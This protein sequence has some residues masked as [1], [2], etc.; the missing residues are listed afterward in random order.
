ML[1]GFGSHCPSGG[2][3]S[4]IVVLPDRVAWS[5]MNGTV[6]CLALSDGR[7][8]WRYDAGGPV[9][10]SGDADDN[11]IVIC[12]NAVFDERT[13]T[14][15]LNTSVETN[16]PD[17][18]GVVHALDH[19]GTLRW[20]HENPEGARFPSL[21]GD[22]VYYHTP[23]GLAAY[24]A[25]GTR[26]WM[27]TEGNLAVAPPALD[28]AAGIGVSAEDF[29]GHH[30]H[31]GLRVTDLATG[32]PLWAVDGSKQNFNP[33]PPVV[34]FGS[35]WMIGF[36][37]REHDRTAVRLNRFDLRSGRL[38]ATVP[39]GTEIESFATCLAAD[40]TGIL[41]SYQGGRG[42]NDGV[43]HIRADNG[44]PRLIQ[45]IPADAAAVTGGRALLATTTQLCAVDVASGEQLWS[46]E[47][48]QNAAVTTWDR[49]VTVVPTAHGV[50]WQ[51]GPT[52][53]M[54]RSDR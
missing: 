32:Q 1:P 24:S 53:T 46:L 23:Y 12:S 11:L 17:A 54:L 31:G 45:P 35:V 10:T 19:D 47:N 34:A 5:S 42:M 2:R 33:D 44:K 4:G 37:F 38:L 43:K 20:Q 48:P 26:H 3:E 7:E 41:V 49:V 6:R 50:L 51:A 40:E 29:E 8:L 25:D 15:V 21:S 36:V 13:H 9:V 14:W 39:L 22:T 52:V 18:G 30:I 28:V 27:D 16:T